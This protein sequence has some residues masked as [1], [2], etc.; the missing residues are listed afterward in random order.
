M[1]TSPG[2]M[3]WGGKWQSRS[4]IAGTGPQNMKFGRS[5]TRPSF[6]ANLNHPGIVPVYDAGWTDDGFFYIVSRFVEGG[7]LSAFLAHG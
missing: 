6:L 5:P 1:S 2:R 7:D 3:S 4:F